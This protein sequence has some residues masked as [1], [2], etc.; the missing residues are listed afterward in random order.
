[1]SLSGTARD[2]P[3]GISGSKRKGGPALEENKSKTA[4]AYIR[5][6]TDDQL[7]YSPDSQLKVIRDYA[8]KSGYLLPETYIFLDEGISGKSAR[9]R[10]AFHRVIALA[11]SPTHPIDAILLWKFS[12][13]ARNQ[14]EAILYKKR[15]AQNGVS[16]VSISE[17]LPDGPFGSLIERIIEWED[18]YYSINLAQEVRRGMTEKATRGQLQATPA[19]GYRA[20]NN[21][22]VPIPEE[23]RL[24]R[25]IFR[26]FAAGEG[27][28]PL[29]KYMNALGTRTHRGNAF[30]RRTIEYIIRNP[31]YIGKLRWNP[32]GRTKRGCWDDQHLIVSEAGHQPLIDFDTWSDAQVRADLLKA[33]SPRPCARPDAPRHHWLCGIV[34][35]ASCGSGLIFAAPHYFKCGGYV[36][37]TCGTSQHIAV[38]SLET[39]FLNCLRR[40]LSA[41]PP[42]FCRRIQNESKIDDR[43]D[44]LRRQLAGVKRKKERLQD[45][46]LSGV[47]TVEEYSNKKSALEREAEET[48]RAIDAFKEEPWVDISSLPIG[49]GD[50]IKLLTSPEASMQEKLEACQA[51]IASCTWDKTTA[52]LSIVYR[53]GGDV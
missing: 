35:C 42:V 39:A 45:A 8:R 48:Q 21:R 31:V 20:E 22:L 24:V 50:I 7:E 25:E 2:K 1:M 38:E 51:I 46:F 23:A 14:E 43:L 13:F 18:E 6:S 10:T 16:V 3:I 12:R 17:P 9:N 36:R 47:D 32:S 41:M 26:R 53:S 4:A 15:L 44:A 37:G 30:E 33:R 28:L 34:R 29:A 40:D 11:R 19:Y 49:P 5:V 27:Y 52:T